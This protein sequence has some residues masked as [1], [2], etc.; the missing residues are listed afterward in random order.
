MS[1]TISK[2][3]IIELATDDDAKYL[4]FPVDTFSSEQIAALQEARSNLLP[5]QF[6]C[7]SSILEKLL[8]VYEEGTKQIPPHM[9]PP[10]VRK[11]PM[12]SG[13]K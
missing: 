8:N 12:Q 13:Y 6:R 4:V 7:L 3:R 9:R 1:N 2:K 10:K 5:P 11:K